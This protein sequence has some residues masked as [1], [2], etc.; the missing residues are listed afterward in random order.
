MLASFFID[1]YTLWKI[2]IVT[3]IIIIFILKTFL[4]LNLAVKFN[5]PL[6]NQLKEYITIF[7]NIIFNKKKIEKCI[8]Y[9][10]ICGYLFI[11][12]SLLLYFCLDENIFPT[13]FENVNPFIKKLDKCIEMLSICIMLF[14]SY[15]MG[16][17]NLKN[18]FLSIKSYNF[19]T[20]Y[21]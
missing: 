3:P 16:L 20:L 11:L 10:S 7:C 15:I 21:Y 6:I 2:S 5:H 1:A 13:D 14:G 9:F 12:K 8:F 17:Y 4:F 18:L 19:N